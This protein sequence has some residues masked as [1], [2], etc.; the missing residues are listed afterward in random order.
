V[1]GLVSS[2]DT[3]DKTLKESLVR[4]LGLIGDERAIVGLLHECGDDRLRSFALNSLRGMGARVGKAV[5]ALFPGADD[6]QRPIIAFICGE[7]RLAGSETVLAEGMRDE[8][9]LLRRVSAM[10]AARGGVGVLTGEIASLL[11][12]PDPGV[13]SDSIDALS[14]LAGDEGGTVER[15]AGELSASNDPEKRRA[16]AQLYGALKM[17]DRLALLLK[18]EDA[19]VR[20]AAV[21]AMAPLDRESR[22]RQLTMALVD[23]NVDVRVAAVEALGEAGGEEVLS[24]LILALKDGDPWVKCAALKSIGRVGH[25]GAEHAVLEVLEESGN[26]L[27]TITALETLARIGG[28]GVMERV[29]GGLDSGDEEVVVAAM[30]IL[31]GRG[32]DWIE[33]YRERLLAHPHWGVRRNFVR[34]MAS[35]PGE[36]AIPHLRRALETETEAIVREQILAI[37]DRNQ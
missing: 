23:E 18:D 9:P 36:D 20:R 11:N 1:E 31:A 3:A 25:R 22:A 14:L 16:A 4:L 35:A 8:D 12:D 15:I 19:T 29:K 7:L 24:S 33:E 10:A 21:E 17:A 5:M 28:E 2:L 13:R 37:L 32:S 27:L 26:G 30:E 6:E 34:A